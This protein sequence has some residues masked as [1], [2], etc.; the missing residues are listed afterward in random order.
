MPVARRLQRSLAALA[1]IVLLAGCGS[2]LRDS[3]MVEDPQGQI[4]GG[5]LLLCEA[6]SPLE[7]VGEDWHANMHVDCE[8]SGEIRLALADGSQA[9]CEVGYVTPGMLQ[10]WLFH[11]EDGACVQV[12]G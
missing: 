2:A 12:T 9:T 1:G 7:Q 6:V 8:G 5:E 4:V 3:F 10:D 11:L